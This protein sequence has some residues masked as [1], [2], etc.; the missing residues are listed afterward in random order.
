MKKSLLYAFSA[1]LIAL[2]TGLILGCGEK[3]GYKAMGQAELEQLSDGMYVVMETNKGNITMKLFYDKAPITVA[4]FVSLVEGKSGQSQRKGPFYD[5]LTFHRVVDGFVVQGGDPSGD[6]TGGPGYKFPDE[7]V[8][9]LSFDGEGILAMANAGPGTNGSQFFITLGATPHLTGKHTIFGRVVSDQDQAVVRK[10]KQGDKMKKVTI[11]RKGADANAFNADRQALI[12][13]G[14]ETKI[15]ETVP[16]A[17]KSPKGSHYLVKKEGTGEKPSSGQEITM[18]YKGWLLDSGK[19]F[20]ASYDRGQPIAFKVGVGQ[21]IPGWDEMGL[22]MKV[23]EK[24]IVVL[25]PTL[26]YGEGGA[27]GV[28]PPSAWLVFEMERIS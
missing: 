19:V 13:K 18:H 5:G 27:G 8:N 16:N 15:A 14:V 25:P 17:K 22:D 23:G 12:D 28:I 6:G 4:N 9:D 2:L 11:I 21:V 20:D 7:I 1:L 10:I 24:R 26:A 3:K